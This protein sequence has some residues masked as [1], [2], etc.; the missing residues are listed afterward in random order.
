MQFTSVL[1]HPS[2][3]SSPPPVYEITEKT[4]SNGKAGKISH[5]SNTEPHPETISH[6]VLKNQNARSWHPQ[7]IPSAFS[8]YRSCQ[9]VNNKVLIGA[10]Q[11]WEQCNSN[12]KVSHFHPTYPSL[13]PESYK[14]I[15]CNINSSEYGRAEHSLKTSDPESKN[16]VN[17]SNILN[18]KQHFARRKNMKKEERKATVAD[19]KT[20]IHLKTTNVR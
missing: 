7:I 16:S 17:I 8:S 2:T 11:P 20:M 4:F 10:S 6:E 14:H 13:E 15:S 1:E 19:R 18:Y 12:S 9:V 5:V 3:N